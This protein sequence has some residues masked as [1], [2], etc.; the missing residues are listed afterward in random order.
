MGL[1]GLVLRTVC[2]VAAPV[3][4]LAGPALIAPQPGWA[5]NATANCELQSL[6]DAH[7]IVAAPSQCVSDEALVISHDVNL[8]GVD[9]QVRGGIQIRSGATLVI[10]LPT[11]LSA[12]VLVEPGASLWLEG[13]EVAVDGLISIGPDGL[14]L[15]DGL[16][17]PVAVGPVA[18]Q[19][20]LTIFGTVEAGSAQGGISSDAETGAVTLAHL[21]EQAKLFFSAPPLGEAA[22][23]DVAKADP[24][25]PVAL[26]DA[27]IE[28]VEPSLTVEGRIGPDGWSLISLVA[29][30]SALAALPSEPVQ[31]ALAAD[32]SPE[33]DPDP[34]PGPE[35]VPLA[36]VVASDSASLQDL[37]SNRPSGSVIKLPTTTQV[38]TPITVG[39]VGSL[40]RVTRITLHDGTLL[41]ATT[42]PMITVPDC[43]RLTL[44][45]VVLDGNKA[46][47]TAGTR[48][49]PI[50]EV[51]PGQPNGC[52]GGELWIGDGTR[53]INNAERGV[54]NGGKVWL[55]G[56][57]AAI[58]GN[59]INI[60]SLGATAPTGGAGVLNKAG[61]TFR[62]ENGI[63]SDN[64]AIGTA[65]VPACGGGVLNAGLMRFESGAIFGNF[66]SGKGGG[67]AI[68]SE[69][70]AERGGQLFIGTELFSY[71]KRIGDVPQLVGNSAHDGGGLAL[72]GQRPESGW[73]QFDLSDDGK[74]TWKTADA[75]APT[76]YLRNGLIGDNTAVHNGGAVW[77]AGGARLGFEGPVV[78]GNNN[79]AGN[80]GAGVFVATAYTVLTAAPVTWPGTG[81]KYDE[82]GWGPLVEADLTDGTVRDQ[83]V[84]DAMAITPSTGRIP[85]GLTTTGVNLTDQ[86]GVL[87]L[88]PS[89]GAE[90]CVYPDVPDVLFVCGEEE[91]VTVSPPPT[92]P[93]TTPTALSTP[94]PTP[95]P[96]PEPKPTPSQFTA[97]TPD[98]TPVVPTASATPTQA[99]PSVTAPPG[100]PAVPNQAAEQNQPAQTYDDPPASDPTDSQPPPDPTSPE[101]KDSSQPV[102]VPESSVEPTPDVEASVNPV[103]PQSLRSLGL[104]LIGLGA[105]GLACLAAFLRHRATLTI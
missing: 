63:I 39:G 83:V 100:N 88:N 42:G 30:E 81:L 11:K 16:P 93:P 21:T 49:G 9:L 43:V 78:I 13:P 17:G 32:P 14:A 72:V 7:Q 65:S 104:L 6:I 60:A 41:R 69:P 71:P 40:A 45:N 95:T 4:L 84:I 37:L 55:S 105:A 34:E 26:L 38:D 58:T 8:S 35:V 73:R 48:P 31:A 99:P 67:I 86:L 28:S 5:E 97:I 2:A 23:F 62:M 92:S 22:R 76:A 61:A 18:N 47:Y 57:N 91:D 98:P 59:T 101:P 12:N 74:L 70:E 19:G 24:L 90:L 85:V 3:V 79:K 29:D 103:T 10:D 20:N 53:L 77:A 46:R 82:P 33:P 64:Q 36:G 102:P 89:D 87:T 54:L 75:S 50:I 44:E 27:V 25:I 15:I 68:V 52:G 66:A 51:L 96:D 56:K 1:K 94:T 80:E